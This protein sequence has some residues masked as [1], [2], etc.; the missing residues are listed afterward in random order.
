MCESMNI[1][2]KKTISESPFSNELFE[3]HNAVLED[4]LLKF[5]MMKTLT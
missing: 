5:H 1:K 3:R 2:V 4:M